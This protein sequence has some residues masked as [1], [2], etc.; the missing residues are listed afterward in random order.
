M[1]G[2]SDFYKT[3]V[4]YVLFSRRTDADRSVEMSPNPGQE[5]ENKTLIDFRRS[6]PIYRYSTSSIAMVSD[7][8]GL[9]KMF[10]RNA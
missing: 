8:G 7:K 5:H 9:H 1:F 4:R 2:K 10:Y 3:N 6:K